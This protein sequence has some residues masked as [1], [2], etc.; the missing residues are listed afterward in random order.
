M[1]K[2]HYFN[3]YLANF[4][5]KLP[6]KNSKGAYIAGQVHLEQQSNFL[7]PNQHLDQDKVLQPILACDIQEDID[8]NSPVKFEKPHTMAL[9]DK[10]LPAAISGSTNSYL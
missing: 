1:S 10:I 6:K 8:M 3:N 2:S 4:K 5:P 7:L 9:N